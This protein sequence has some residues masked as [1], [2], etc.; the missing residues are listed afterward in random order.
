[1]LYLSQMLGRPVVDSS[2][3]ELGKISDIAVQTGEVFPRITSFAF[4]GPAKTP[5]M[6]SW[7]KYVENYGSFAS[8]SPSAS[9]NV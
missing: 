5:F 6:V 9:A 1:M 3:V 4:K 7:R 2:G 8:T